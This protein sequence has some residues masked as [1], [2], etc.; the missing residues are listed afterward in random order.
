M[1]VVSLRGQG[2]W[3]LFLRIDKVWM[4]AAEGAQAWQKAG[5]LISME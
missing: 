1:T 5:L 4:V 3:G 2:L